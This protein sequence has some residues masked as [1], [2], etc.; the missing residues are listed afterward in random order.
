M[1]IP[2]DLAQWVERW[3]GEPTD[4]ARGRPA[5]GINRSFDK[6]NTPGGRGVAL[7]HVMEAL[8]EELR[9]DPERQ[10]AIVLRLRAEYQE[11]A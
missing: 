3:V 6:A 9:D 4:L 8:I 2:V 7:N 10:K 11:R 1:R 5:T